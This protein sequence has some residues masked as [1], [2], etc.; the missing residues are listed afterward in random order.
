MSATAGKRSDRDQRERARR[1]GRLEAIGVSG[2]CSE[3]P[4]PPPWPGSYR[5][6]TGSE[7]ERQHDRAE[8]RAADSSVGARQPHLAR[9]AERR[10]WS[11]LIQRKAVA[12]RSHQ[13]CASD[14]VGRCRERSLN[15]CRSRRPKPGLARWRSCR[16]FV[17]GHR[18]PFH[19]RRSGISSAIVRS[20]NGA[21]RAGRWRAFSCAARVLRLQARMHW[22]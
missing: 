18:P 20:P 9:L 15:G 4:R 13:S 8:Q 7:H 10:P 12:G 1:F 5:A 2:S 16:R 19:G 17:P 21:R 22:G 14:G 11:C 3:R 6:E